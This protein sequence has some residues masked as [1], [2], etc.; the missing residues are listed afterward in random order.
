MPLP[1]TSSSSDARRLWAVVAVLLL[2]VLTPTVCVL[3]FMNQAVANERWAV[4]QR[5]Q[6]V[7]RGELVNR[8]QRL[9]EPWGGLRGMLEEPR[10]TGGAPARQPVSTFRDLLKYIDASSVLIYRDGKMVYPRMPSEPVADK[11]L[12][13]DTREAQALLAQAHQ[14]LQAGQVDDAGDILGWTMQDI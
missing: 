4:R 2:A 12:S 13:E 11:P 5:L 6:E 1:W 7:Y 14:L 9:E 3:W 8:R 10:R